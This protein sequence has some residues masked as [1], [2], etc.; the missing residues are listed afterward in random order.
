MFKRERAILKQR[1][2]C[3]YQRN[4]CNRWSPNRAQCIR[5]IRSGQD[6]SF[7]TGR[8]GIRSWRGFQM[9]GKVWVLGSGELSRWSEQNHTWARCLGLDQWLWLTW[10]RVRKLQKAGRMLAVR[11][12]LAPTWSALPGNGKCH[13]NWNSLEEYLSSRWQLCLCPLIDS[14]KLGQLSEVEWN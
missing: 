14:L 2:H 11:T 1:H 7:V 5:Q 12:K 6:Q 13:E 10:Y 4:L 8:M 9:A 3:H